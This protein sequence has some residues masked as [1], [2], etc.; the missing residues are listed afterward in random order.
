MK[1]SSDI[2]IHIIEKLDIQKQNKLTKDLKEVRGI[3]SVKLHEKRPHLMIVGFDHH[4]TKAL[5]VLDN[6][7]QQG[8]QAQ[9]VGWV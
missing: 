4:E 6:V 3:V 9:L 2:V 8:V 1:N 5:N 7:K